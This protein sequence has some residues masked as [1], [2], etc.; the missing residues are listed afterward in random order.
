MS[1]TPQS[2]ADISVIGRYTDK[3]GETTKVFRAMKWMTGMCSNIPSRGDQMVRYY[4]LCN[5]V[6][7]FSTIGNHHVNADQKSEDS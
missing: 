6:R 4:G 1:K 5:T 7:D 3:Y 2:I